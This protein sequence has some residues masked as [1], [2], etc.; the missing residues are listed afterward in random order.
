Q[1]D[2]VAFPTRR[3][4]DAAATAGV[5]G[6]PYD[7]VP[8]AATGTGLGN[9]SISYVNGKLTVTKKALSITA[10][11]QSKGYGTSVSFTGSEFAV[12]A[13]DLNITRTNVTDMPT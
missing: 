11:D 4:S 10:N 8:S 12:P 6:S 13:G 5:G 3:T 7:I 2:T 1:R 9:Y